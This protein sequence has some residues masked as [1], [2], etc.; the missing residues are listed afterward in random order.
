MASYTIK[1]QNLTF[2]LPDEGQIF[3]AVGDQGDA[4][5][6]IVNGVPQQIA[7]Q[8][9]IA[10]TDLRAP[11]GTIIKAGQPVPTGHLY[12]GGY[13]PVNPG[14]TGTW[15]A[16]SSGRD[17][18]QR[19]GGDWESLPEFNMADIQTVL[20]KTGG[21]LPTGATTQAA[22]PTLVAYLKDGTVPGQ[23]T[24][25][26]TAPTTEL[27]PGDTGEQ[28]KQL[29]DY[30]V[31][32]GLM[33]REEVNTGYGTYGPKTTAA[34][35]KLQTQLGVD[36]TSGVG[37]Y[38]PKTIAAAGGGTGTGTGGTTD[39]DSADLDTILSN[40]NLSDDQ[41]DVIRAIYDAVSTNDTETAD[42]IKAAMSAASQYSDPYFKAQVRLVTDALSRG[43]ASEE[44]DLAF[45]EASLRNALTDLKA[46]LGASKTNSSIEHTK[47]L[48][49]LAK[50]YE[51]DLEDT[52]T[53]LAASGFTQSSRRAR[54]E[55]LLA[56][57]NEGLVESSNRRFSFE[58]DQANRNIA[59]GERDTALQL[60]NA[61]RLASEGKLDLLRR[62]E[63]TVG[64]NELSS[65]GHSGLGGVGGS[66][67]RA[68]ALDQF[69]FASGFVF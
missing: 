59:G 16:R 20:N 15:A 38:G 39:G 35:Q 11:D 7:S 18:F 4:V 23:S 34:V 5:Y 48:Q 66:I 55:Q 24:P 65:A 63:E 12:E 21:K 2:N 62:T 51:I 10:N 13:R 14:F 57:E 52:R 41:K 33:T 67:P 25:Q 56:E 44:G 69:Q 6:K 28:V 3:R 61:Q 32:Q 68:Q 37:Y 29:Q 30:L 40:P 31:S 36:N 45:K 64:S 17:A 1:E 46:D 54:A 53:G 19:Q 47:E 49:Q 9:W 58:T 60:A 27:K 43:L 22:D 26:T 42:R 8:S 50:K